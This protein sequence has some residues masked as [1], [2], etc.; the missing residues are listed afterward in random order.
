MKEPE[1][2]ADFTDPGHA[3][4]AGPEQAAA[5]ALQREQIAK[6]ADEPALVDTELYRWCRLARAA[7]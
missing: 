2:D 5:G 3:R 7:V 1:G 6:L 4:R